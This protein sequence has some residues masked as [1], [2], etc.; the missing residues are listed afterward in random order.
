M[1]TENPASVPMGQLHCLTMAPEHPP[2]WSG[3]YPGFFPN[4]KVISSTFACFL[5]YRSLLGN[6]VITVALGI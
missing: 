4:F 5:L 2:M 3:L 1:Q 6:K